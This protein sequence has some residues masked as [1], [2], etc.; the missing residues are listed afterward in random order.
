MTNVTFLKVPQLYYNLFILPFFRA[1]S[2]LILSSCINVCTTHPPLLCVGST[3]DSAQALI[4]RVFSHR[5][6]N[7][8]RFANVNS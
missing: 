8:I 4:T 7:L 5:T 6:F 1:Y 3:F 2:L